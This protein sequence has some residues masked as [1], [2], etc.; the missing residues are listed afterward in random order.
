MGLECTSVVEAPGVIHLTYR[1][2]NER[3]GVRT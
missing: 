2:V 3:S 1:V